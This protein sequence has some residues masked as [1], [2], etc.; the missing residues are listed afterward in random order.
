MIRSS[1]WPVY[2]FLYQHIYL[3]LANIGSVTL[4][5]GNGAK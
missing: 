4:A 5:I 1:I 3:N 2:A